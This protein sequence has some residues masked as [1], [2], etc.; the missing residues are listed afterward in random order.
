M[1]YS[2][3]FSEAISLCA[4]DNPIEFMG[5]LSSEDEEKPKWG[6]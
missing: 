2:L 6:H 4:E 5:N 1:N 3:R